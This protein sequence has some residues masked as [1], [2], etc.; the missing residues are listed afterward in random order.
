MCNIWHTMCHTPAVAE[1]NDEL[2]QARSRVASP[3]A[4]NESMSRRELAEA[5]NAWIYEHCDRRMAELDETYIS[6]LERGIIRWPRDP[7]RRAAF[8]AV[9]GVQ[10]DRELG[11][12]RPRR[13]PRTV[14]S[15]DRQQFLRATLGVSAGTIVASPVAGLVSSIEVSRMPSVVGRD[16][17][18]QI[19]EADEVILTAGHVYGGGTLR[20]AALAQLRYAANLLDARCPE[21]LR[22]ELFSAV[23]ALACTVGF[24]AFD[25]N[26]HDNARRLFRFALVCIEEAENWHL[27][28]DVLKNLALQAHW[29]GDHDASL[30]YLDLAMVRSDRLTPAGRAVL[31]CGRARALAGLGRT[32]E[33]RAAVGTAD[34]EFSRSDPANEPWNLRWYDTAQ[35]HSATG[36]ALATLAQQGRF[37]DDATTRLNT[38]VIT[39][40]NDGIRNRTLDQIRLATLIMTTGDPREAA[41]IGMQATETA[42]T[43]RSGRITD[44]LRKLR[45][46]TT[47]HKAIPEVAELRQRLASAA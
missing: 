4:P 21:R 37:T 25:F 23:G 1:P 47:P 33:V 2:R 39:R 45:Q 26:D 5:V 46:A 42:A 43:L 20:Y 30:T 12:R 41:A 28:V 19:L 34:E 40:G 22:S 8:R 24:N 7:E 36:E 3:V 17:I 13:S 44:T 32:P 15:V 11:F 31:H 18:D 27:R 35:H 14:L 16:E 10:T 38:A 29:L 9:L 6:K